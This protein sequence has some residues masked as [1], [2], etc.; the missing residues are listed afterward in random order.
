MYNLM[1]N[2]ITYL[3][4]SLYGEN[5]PTLNSF[6]SMLMSNKM[7]QIIN[8]EFKVGFLFSPYNE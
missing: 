6:K 4:N 8:K 3:F 5:K 2:I 1:R 7:T